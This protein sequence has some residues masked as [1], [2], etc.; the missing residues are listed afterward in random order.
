MATKRKKLKAVPVQDQQPEFMD[1]FNSFVSEI[2]R[3]HGQSLANSYRSLREREAEVMVQQ[4]A[5]Y[6]DAQEQLQEYLS[7]RM[8]QV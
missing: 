7:F 5:D 4:G 6:P 8:E 2:S 3:L 1:S